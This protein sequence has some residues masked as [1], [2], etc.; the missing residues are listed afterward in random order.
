MLYARCFIVHRSIAYTITQHK[1]RKKQQ[2]L[3]AKK[4]LTKGE[5]ERDRR[6]K[7]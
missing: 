4:A 7:K 2:K 6:E 3:V 5:R 1:Q